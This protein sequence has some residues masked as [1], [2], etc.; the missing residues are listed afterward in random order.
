MDGPVRVWLDREGS[1][2]L[3]DGRATV[4]VQRGLGLVPA[5]PGRL[6]RPVEGVHKHQVPNTAWTPI[7]NPISGMSPGSGLWTPGRAS[8]RR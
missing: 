8:P 4:T 2:G 3:R 5:V 7:V 1:G 6:P